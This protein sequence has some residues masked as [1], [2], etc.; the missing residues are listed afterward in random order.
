MAKPVTI[1]ILLTLPVQSNWFLHQ[2][3]VS[4]AFLHGFLKE[5]VYMTQPPG[6]IDPNHPS[7]VCH[8]QKSLYGLKQAPRAWFEKL[9]SALFTMGFQASQFDPSLFMLHQPTLVLVLVYVDDIIVTG[10]STTTCTSVISQLS[11]PVSS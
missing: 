8:L 6:F 11:A 1:R 4:N 2:L 9:Q 7:F 3:D 5:N 10:P